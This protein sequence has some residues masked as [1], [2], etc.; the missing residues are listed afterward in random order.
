MVTN[1]LIAGEIVNLDH[2]V[3]AKLIIG[4]GADDVVVVEKDNNTCLR[5]TDV[6]EARSFW[7]WLRSTC[8]YQG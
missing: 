7:V 8:L 5:I 6:K 3:S 1:V 4:D 2:V